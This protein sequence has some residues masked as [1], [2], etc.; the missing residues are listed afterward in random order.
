[1]TYGSIGVHVVWILDTLM[2]NM[3]VALDQSVVFDW[4]GHKGVPYNTCCLA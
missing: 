4:P 1:M 2:L 3:K